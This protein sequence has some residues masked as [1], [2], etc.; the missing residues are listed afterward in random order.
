MPIKTKFNSYVAPVVQRQ[1]E[2][3][4]DY[5][6]LGSA[7]STLG[8][9]VGKSIEARDTATAEKA[10]SEYQTKSAIKLKEL[11]LSGEKDVEGSLKLYQDELSKELLDGNE[12]T[13]SRIF[14][15]NRFKMDNPLSIKAKAVQMNVD[16]SIQHND[17][18]LAIANRQLGIRADPST[19]DS[20]IADTYKMIDSPTSYLNTQQ[21]LDMKKK[22]TAD[23]TTYKILG[24]YESGMSVYDVVNNLSKGGYNVD[25]EY[26]EAS[27]D[28]AERAV[29]ARTL[30][31]QDFNARLQND[32]E[33]LK[34]DIDNGKYPWKTKELG[35]L[36]GP[37]DKASMLS[38]LDNA[39]KKRQITIDDRMKQEE[40]NIWNMAV[41]GDATAIERARE[42]GTNPNAT[43]ANQ[44]RWEW[45]MSKNP[46]DCTTK[47]DVFTDISSI[48]EEMASVDIDEQATETQESGATRFLQLQ[49]KA[50]RKFQDFNQK[51]KSLSPDDRKRWEKLVDTFGNL[52]LDNKKLF[53]DSFKFAADTTDSITKAAYKGTPGLKAKSPE[54]QK[55]FLEQKRFIDTHTKI[56]INSILDA[57]TNPNLTEEQRTNLINQAKAKYTSIARYTLHPYLRDIETHDLIKKDS[58]VNINGIPYIF[59]GLQENGIT[60]LIELKR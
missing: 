6:G 55:R 10:M 51:M 27:L 45:L 28:K 58:I 8:Q 44:E 2:T 54:E 38:Q 30:I 40:L 42:L 35:E 22:V 60:P 4:K 26:G 23:F 53:A 5:S 41:Q 48:L 56:Y 7:L 57:S 1:M 16:A 13:V 14:T 36:I 32:P 25:T 17:M 29:A 52:S 12:G 46:V 50:Y 18:Q 11:E 49:I 20:S 34:V 3:P 31:T 33:G 21:R 9:L 37:K 24:D 47:E 43:K 15:E 39:L 19:F 59:K